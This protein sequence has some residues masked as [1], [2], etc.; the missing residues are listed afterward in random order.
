MA[1]MFIVASAAAQQTQHA[2]LERLRAAIS[3]SC[4]TFKCTYSMYVS[5]TRVEG[6]ADVMIQ[7]NAYM[8]SADGLQVYCDGSKVWTVDTSVKEVYVEQAVGVSA[9]LDP[10]SSDFVFD[11]DGNPVNT[12]QTGTYSNLTLTYNGAVLCTDYTLTVLDSNKALDYPEYPTPGSVSVNKGTTTS[13]EDFSDT[14]V[15]NIQ[16]SGT[17]IPADKGVDLIVIMDLS[18]SMRYHVYNSQYACGPMY[19]TDGTLNTRKASDYTTQKQQL[20]YVYNPEWWTY[21]RMYALEESL[22]LFQEGTE[23]VRNCQKLLD[24][25][26]LQV[27]MIMTAQDGSPVEEDFQDEL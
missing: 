20:E 8:M 11:A 14:G 21:T 26:Q 24:E 4:V 9:F 19:N 13:E 12:A 16:L 15:A 18:S 2:A 25:A 23:L 10:T 3:D 17:A 7:G 5:Q 22:K 6:N 27:K 1:V